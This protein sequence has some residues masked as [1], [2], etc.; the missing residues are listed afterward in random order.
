MYNGN[1]YDVFFEFKQSV[2][3]ISVFSRHKKSR[4][5]M[6]FCFF[7][8]RTNHNKHLTTNIYFFSLFVRQNMTLI[9]VKQSLLLSLFVFSFLAFLNE[10]ESDVSRWKVNTSKR[11]FFLHKIY[12]YCSFIHF[13]LGWILNSLGSC[14]YSSLILVKY[15][16]IC[17]LNEFN[18]FTFSRQTK[19]FQNKDCF[20]VLIKRTL[21][22]KTCQ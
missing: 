8:S 6:F 20:E 3:V 11:T 7:F 12:W 22:L 16:H 2:D 18:Y 15:R 14:R 10:N 1:C 17:I 4:N 13:T 21:Q 19:R 9:R 5:K